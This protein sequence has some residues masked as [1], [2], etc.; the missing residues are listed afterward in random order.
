[1]HAFVWTETEAHAK[2]LKAEPD[3]LL[4]GTNEANHALRH[5]WRDCDV[6]PEVLW[7]I[8]LSE[9]LQ[10]IGKRGERIDFFDEEERQRRINA[11]AL[12][13]WRA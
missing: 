1:M 7:P 4:L 8:L 12:K 13:R 5:G 3:K 9:A 6:E 11:L 2:R 10:E